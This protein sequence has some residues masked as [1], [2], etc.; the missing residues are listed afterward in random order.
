MLYLIDSFLPPHLQPFLQ[1]S[2]PY[3]PF[4][5]VADELTEALSPP[6]LPELVGAASMGVPYRITA[7][8]PLIPIPTGAPSP[9]IISPPLQ[10]EWKRHFRRRN[11]LGRY[12]CL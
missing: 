8:V 4:A 11:S 5:A 9:H 1:P 7:S 12:Q 6:E 10:M 2:Y 3:S